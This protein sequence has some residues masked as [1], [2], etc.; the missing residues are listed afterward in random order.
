MPTKPELEKTLK[1]LNKEN[2]RLRDELSGQADRLEV[3]VS[4]EYVERLEAALLIL[5]PFGGSV[6][7]AEARRSATTDIGVNTARLR[8]AVDLCDEIH[9]RE[10]AEALKGA[11]Q[12][13]QAGV[14][15]AEKAAETS[16]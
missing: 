13:H 10:E 16:S 8:T 7:M 5:S 9:A 6:K 2:E 14:A 15:D 11:E 3:G 12:E 1:E 4:A